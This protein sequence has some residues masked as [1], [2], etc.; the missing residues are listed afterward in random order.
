M[1]RFIVKT[2]N[3]L[4]NQTINDI[5]YILINDGS[6]DFTLDIIKEMIVSDE[7]FVIVNQNNFG[8][9]YSCNLGIEISSG[10][11][12]AIYEPDDI[13]TSDF[14]EKL[15]FYAKE[16]TTIDVFRYNGFFIKKN[17]EIKKLY[18]WD[19]NIAN[20]QLDKYEHKRFWRSHPSVFNG[21]YK[22]SFLKEKN[23]K[24]CT[25]RGASF[26]DV[27]FMVSLFYS[28][29]SIFVIN[30]AKYYYNIHDNQSINN[31]LKKI[32]DIKEN[33][34]Q[35][36]IWCRERKIADYSFF[37]YKMFMQILNIS[38][39]DRGVFFDFF[40]IFPKHQM[41]Y[42]FSPVGTFRQNLLIQFLMAIIKLR[43]IFNDK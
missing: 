40:D 13:I 34:N 32:N 6:T 1:E 43:R 11:Y 8:Y 30:D 26:Q 16:N 7:K 24:F 29:P 36:Y 3:C 33:W 21:I 18:T 12:V 5:E 15:L 23:V 38:K 4:K 22:K 35:E 20:L 2:I 39:N 28:N 37:Y 14:Y 27:Q 19:K 42:I 31:T 25:A 9:G 10:K 17:D 41:K